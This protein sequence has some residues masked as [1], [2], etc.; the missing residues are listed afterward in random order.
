VVPDASDVI[1]A[2]EA[3]HVE[4][5]LAKTVYGVYASESGTNHDNAVMLLGTGLFRDRHCSSMAAH[6]AAVETMLSGHI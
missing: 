6:L 1:G 2:L 5:E 4:A 3:K